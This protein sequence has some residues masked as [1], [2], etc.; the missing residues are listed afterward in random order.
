RPAKYIL[1]PLHNHIFPGVAQASIFGQYQVPGLSPSYNGP[2]FQ[3]R[4]SPGQF[5]LI[6]TLHY[7]EYR[8]NPRSL[9]DKDVILLIPGDPG[10]PAH[11]F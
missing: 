5:V 9:R 1:L 7:P 4:S 3:T 6:E 11:I 2:S 10:W 8:A